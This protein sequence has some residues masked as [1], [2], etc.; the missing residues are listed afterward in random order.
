MNVADR[1]R[2]VGLEQYVQPFAGRDISAKVLR[3]LTADD[4]KDLG[5]A[6]VGN[7]WRIAVEALRG[8]VATD[9]RHPGSRV[10]DEPSGDRAEVGRIGRATSDDRSVHPREGGRGNPGRRLWNQHYHRYRN[11]SC[12]PSSR[13]TEM[14]CWALPYSR[15]RSKML[16]SVA[17][18]LNPAA[19]TCPPSE[20]RLRWASSQW[21]PSKN[22]IGLRAGPSISS[23]HLAFT[24][25]LSGCERGT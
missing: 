7:R 23:R 12:R 22:R 10:V 4:L 8:V 16:L 18:P 25:I 20:I 2:H 5:I 11:D 1:L 24:V 14:E 17:S 13:G 9:P 21:R 6:Q 19:A 3:H 15:A